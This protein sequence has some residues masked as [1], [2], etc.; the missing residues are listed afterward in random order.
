MPAVHVVRDQG[1]VF[2][3]F[4]VTE[5]LNSSDD[6][7]QW[8]VTSLSSLD[9]L[10]LSLEWIKDG[11]RLQGSNPTSP[12]TR[13]LRI[14]ANHEALP[15]MYLVLMAKEGLDE[16]YLGRLVDAS[17]IDISRLQQWLTVC[18]NGHQG[19]HVAPNSPAM[20]RLSSNRSFRLIDVDKECIVSAKTQPFLAL[21]YVWGTTA[22]ATTKSGNI[23]T[24]MQPGGL[25]VETWLPRTIRDA[26]HLTRLL[27][28]RYLWVDALCIIQGNK[29]DWASN[30]IVM[31]AVYERAALT[32]CA[33]GGQ[34]STFGIRGLTRG[35][36]KF[37][38]AIVRYSKE[39]QL[40]ITRPAE[41]FVE[42]S[43][44]NTRAW[45]F[46]ERICSRRGFIFVNDRVF[47]QC[48][49]SVMCEDIT[50][51]HDALLEEWSLET[52]DALG[53]LF[54]ENPIR[55]YTKYVQL[56]TQRTLTFSRDRLPA[57]SAIQ[58]LLC[59]RMNTAFRMGL[60]TSYFDF[61]LLWT[62][63]QSHG[64][65]SMRNPKYPSWTWAGWEN[66]SEYSYQMLE[67][68]LLNMHEWLSTR[69]WIEWYTGDSSTEATLVWD[70]NKSGLQGRWKGYAPPNKGSYG[71]V[72]A[73]G[74][75]A[76]DHFLV[77]TEQS[78][79]FD[80]RGDFLRGSEST[81]LQFFT[82]SAFFGVD[83][84]PPSGR[85]HLGLHD[86][87]QWHS[88]FD[89]EG[90]WC[91]AVLL[92]RRWVEKGEIAV[93]WDYNK[94]NSVQDESLQV[95]RPTRKT[96]QFIAISE[97]R[98][99]STQEHDSWTYYVPKD[100]VDSQWDL[101]YVLLIVTDEAGRSE[102]RGLGKVFKDAFK[103]SHQPGYS[104]SEITL[105]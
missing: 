93:S 90:D 94:V 63:S 25:K 86:C 2:C 81:Y 89:A 79:T 66:A 100:R 74:A 24:L 75:G 38:Q 18:Q 22:F 85:S 60:P 27:G 35:S 91:G 72:S 95:Q 11:R 71:R 67:G 4:I 69:T 34:D 77:Q 78:P 45:T 5:M 82:H 3:N 41:H 28:Y 52:R 88:L 47:Y 83:P 55:Q 56:Y 32:I 50:M 21:S 105:Y 29:D 17:A 26:I 36:R 33:A 37:Q 42:R 104:W 57:F 98:E 30:A 8:S 96:Y 6:P 103:R 9:N 48:R 102:R 59:E 15:D 58:A 7:Q 40:M 76:S 73:S 97:A 12:S 20:D 61:A 49:Q 10:Q 65:L 99:F 1:C 13:R 31:D 19:C 53:R 87:P 46:Q 14:S 44:W 23:D 64:E 54:L 62:P 51:E 84:E 70:G 16:Q 101:F 68:V 39:V 92:D 80:A 43:Q